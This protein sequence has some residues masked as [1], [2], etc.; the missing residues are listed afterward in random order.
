MKDVLNTLKN[1]KFDKN[2]ENFSLIESNRKVD[3]KH[4]EKMV[5]SLR[6]MGIIRP[7]VC[8]ETDIIEGKLKRYIIDGQHL[9]YACKREEID[10]PYILLDVKS[11]MELVYKMALVNNSSKSWDLMN[12]ITAYKAVN[13]DYQKLYDMKLKYNMEVSMIAALGMNISS[14]S[15]TGSGLGGVTNIIKEGKYKFTNPKSDIM[16]KDFSDIFIAIGSADRWV[17]FNFFAQFMQNYGKYNHPKTIRNIKIHIG[18][19]K[20]MS[21]MSY[22]RE[23]IQTK[24]FETA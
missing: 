9:F 11:N 15:F 3:S 16:C 21:D 22:A 6:T 5:V 1:M 17:K 8:I 10:V 12:Y 7:V 24:I 13:D 2:Y 19:I 20:A 14:S 18:T 23:F 4:S